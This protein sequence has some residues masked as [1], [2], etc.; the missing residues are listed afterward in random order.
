[1]TLR[2]CQGDQQRLMRVI[3]PAASETYRGAGSRTLRIVSGPHVPEPARAVHLLPYTANRAAGFR[4]PVL[5]HDT[6]IPPET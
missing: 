5:E 3:S 2:I 1:M 6:V 4:L